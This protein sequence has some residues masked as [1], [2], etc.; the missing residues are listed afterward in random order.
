MV[1][2]DNYLYFHSPWI[3]DLDLV[4]ITAPH[5]IVNSGH[6]SNGMV[7]TSQIQ[8]VIVAQIPTTIC[9]EKNV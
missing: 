3:D 5:K 6:T 9:K 4:S 2:I 8:Q 1:S 7:R